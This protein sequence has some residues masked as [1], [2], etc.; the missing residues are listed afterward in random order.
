V[1]ANL[2]DLSILFCAVLW[3]AAPGLVA[4]LPVWDTTYVSG[5]S[6]WQ[7]SGNIW[8]FVVIPHRRIRLTDSGGIHCLTTYTCVVRRL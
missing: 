5:T 7:E 6:P 3:A 8:A 4:V 2:E 1:L